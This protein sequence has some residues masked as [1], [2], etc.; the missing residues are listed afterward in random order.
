MTHDDI[1]EVVFAVL[2]ECHSRGIH[3][4]LRQAH[5][6]AVALQLADRDYADD[7]WHC[8]SHGKPCPCGQ[9]GT[10]RLHCGDLS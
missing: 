8:A 4:T 6:V 7:E 5:A 1:A 9:P 10:H 3:D 2:N